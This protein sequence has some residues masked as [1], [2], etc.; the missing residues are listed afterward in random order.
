M[1]ISQSKL[2][3]KGM[4]M[5]AADAVPGVSGGT[6]AVMLHIYERLVNAI[7]AAVPACRI[8]WTGGGATVAWR[9]LDGSFL[10]VLAAG[11]LTSLFLVA[12]VVLYLL[13]THYP[14]VMAFF[15]GIVLASACF[16]WNE[17]GR[18]SIQAVTACLLSGAMIVMISLASPVEIPEPSA[19][20]LFLSGAV[21][22]SAMILPGLSGAFILLLMG[23]YAPVLTAL[24]TFQW[25]TILVFAVGC[26][27]GLLSFSHVLAWVFR[28]YRS[29]TYAAII[30]MLVASLLALWPWKDTVTDRGGVSL[31]GPDGYQA[32]SG[33]AAQPEAVFGLMVAGFLLVVIFERMTGRMVR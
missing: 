13:E 22:I 1:V 5:G 18:W 19:F 27:C 29:Q 4:A 25:S 17:V 16:L 32:V 6:I 23:V 33:Q 28:R 20:Y 15:C 31:L 21:A 14:L 24:R 9:T 12:N 30:G 11:V 3:L 8:L 10:V 26:L 2:F 7:R